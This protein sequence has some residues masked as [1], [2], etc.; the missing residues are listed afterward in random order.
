MHVKLAFVAVV[1]GLVVWDVG[2]GRNTHSRSRSSLDRSRSC[3]SAFRSP[4]SGRQCTCE[5]SADGRL[6]AA[7]LLR[8]SAPVSRAPV[9]TPMFAMAG[10]ASTEDQHARGGGRRRWH[11]AASARAG[12]RART[13]MGGGRFLQRRGKHRHAACKLLRATEVAW[14]DSWKRRLAPLQEDSTA[15]GRRSGGLD[16]VVWV[17]DELLGGAL[18]EVL[19]SVRGV[20]EVMIVALT[21][22]AM[23]ARSFRIICIRP[24]W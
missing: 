7:R 4:T 14:S 13:S 2:A 18:V 12:R 5:C 20:V 11:H 6:R 15:Y 3:G 19:V 23:C 8:P 22:F 10:I 24:W 21:A 9:A 1:A 17:E 16:Q